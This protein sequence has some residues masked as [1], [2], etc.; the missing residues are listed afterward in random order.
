M[1]QRTTLYQ[2]L[3][4]VPSQLVLNHLSQVLTNI[5]GI[6]ITRN[7]TMSS[8]GGYSALVYA[9][10][11]TWS[12][13]ARRRKAAPGLQSDPASICSSA[14]Q[15][16]IV[17]WSSTSIDNGKH[18]EPCLEYQWVD[19]RERSVFESFVSHVN[20]KLSSSITAARPSNH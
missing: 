1:P 15:C 9:L 7:T 12:R 16:R 3:C 6:T 8:L 20:R 10:G 4:G 14:L 2:Q 18:K 11:D 19:G 13:S 5:S 17:F